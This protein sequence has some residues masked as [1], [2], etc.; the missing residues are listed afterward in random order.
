M[1]YSVPQID[2]EF[3]SALMDQDDPDTVTTA[4]VLYT[5][6]MLQG[7]SSVMREHAMMLLL[8]GM[9][10]PYVDGWLDAADTFDL[11][12]P[13]QECVCEEHEKEA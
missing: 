4:L 12:P 10:Q 13:P 9:Q 8:Q 2:P 7:V 3:V 5:I 11:D 1:A 6:G